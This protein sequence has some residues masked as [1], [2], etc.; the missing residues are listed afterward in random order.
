MLYLTTADAAKKLCCSTEYV[1]VL[2]RMGKLPAERTASGQ[3][4][5]KAADVEKLAAEREAQR[6]AK[7]QGAAQVA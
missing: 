3:R 4:I 7:T 6:R 2:E 1:R 5:F